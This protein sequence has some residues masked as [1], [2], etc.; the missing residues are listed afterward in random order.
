MTE[1][2][3]VEVDG[4]YTYEDAEYIYTFTGWEGGITLPETVTESATYTMLF[5]KEKKTPT[6][7]EA[8]EQG[9]STVKVYENGVLYILRNG[10]KYTSSGTII[11]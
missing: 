9:A 6:N 3:I 10:K 5:D 8:I 2:E 11:E 4:K 1:F 7:I